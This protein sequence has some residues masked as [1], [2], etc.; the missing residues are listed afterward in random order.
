MVAAA[1]SDYRGRHHGRL[2]SPRTERREFVSAPAINHYEGDAGGRPAV[3]HDA[4]R[5]HTFGAQ[6]RTDLISAPVL[7]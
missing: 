2:H 1:P 6:P 3:A 5:L 7:T 4:T